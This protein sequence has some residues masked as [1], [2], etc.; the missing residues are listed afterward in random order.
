M[1]LFFL[2]LVL[3]LANFAF[4]Q[5]VVKSSDGGQELMR[6][7]SDGRVG[8]GTSSPSTKFDVI[9]SAAIGHLR[10]DPVDDPTGEGAEIWMQ[11]ATGQNGWTVD[12]YADNFRIFNKDNVTVSNV[13]LNAGGA[14][15]VGSL[16][17][18]PSV[19]L[20]VAGKLRLDDADVVEPSAAHFLL[21]DQTGYVKQMQ[22]DPT[23]FSSSN[24]RV[25]QFG[26]E[27]M[28]ASWG[29]DPHYEMRD[30]HDGHV[31]G[32]SASTEP[33][34][35]YVTTV[36]THDYVEILQGM[37]A[38][39]YVDGDNVSLTCTFRIEAFDGSDWNP[40]HGT[41]NSKEITG[42]RTNGERF[43]EYW[44][45]EYNLTALDDGTLIRVFVQRSDGAKA[46]ESKCNVRTAIHSDTGGIYAPGLDAFHSDW[47]SRHFPW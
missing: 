1:R 37:Y 22:F 45:N 25:E 34:Y 12:V 46:G 5:M 14:L 30:L 11:G 6:V 44:V 19:R 47:K 26:G 29:D 27:Y 13:V 41:S 33:Q 39:K 2:F 10:L 4:S 15:G 35:D 42:F 17:P 24:I 3:S 38:G 43:Q 7:T 18:D 16:A 8:I 23:A 32:G 28:G 21:R 36:K 31:T 20:H 40:V 9:G